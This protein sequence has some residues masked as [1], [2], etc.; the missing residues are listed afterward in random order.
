ML[1]PLPAPDL[2]ACGA[3][4]TAMGTNTQAKADGSVAIGTDSTGQGAVATQKD[5]FVLGT[6]NADLHC[7]GY[8][9]RPEQIAPVGAT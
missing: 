2:C 4:S 5:E 3:Y 7:A 6:K 8:H 9:L 1:P